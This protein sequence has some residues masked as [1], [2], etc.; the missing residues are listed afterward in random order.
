MM[1][2]L[3]P[4]SLD[5]AVMHY[6]KD[7]QHTRYLAGGTQVNRLGRS[8]SLYQ[9]VLISSL[10]DADIIREDKRLTIGAGATLQDLVDHAQ[11]P[12][13]LKR[14]CLFA[15]S[16]TLRC[17]ATVGGNIASVRDDS[18]LLPLLGALNGEVQFHDGESMALDIYLGER[19][20]PSGSIITRVVIPDCTIPVFLERA[21]RSS[22]TKPALTVACS[23]G[24]QFR[25]Y[26]SAAGQFMRRLQEVEQLAEQSA[27]DQRIISLVQR[28]IH[29]ADDITGTGRYKQYLAGVL[30]AQ[31]LQELKGKRKEV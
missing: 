14:A 18:Y 9:G 30:I 22:Q 31:G 24:D 21:S 5:E 11:V 6:R 1:N 13:S 10:V 16:R 2:V 20:E 19:R 4:G 8:Q 17:M 15:Q 26:C 3:I 28:T 25:V 27:D 12:E 23:L 7:P 29:P